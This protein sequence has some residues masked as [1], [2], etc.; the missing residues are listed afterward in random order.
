MAWKERSIVEARVSF[1]TDHAKGLMSMTELCGAYGISRQTGYTWLGRARRGESLRD[2][3]RAPRRCPHRTDAALERAIV[4]MRVRHPTWGPDKI[5]RV[6]SDRQPGKRWPSSTTVGEVLKRH[7]LV[8]PRRRR[9]AID[10]A[11][12]TPPRVQAERANDVWCGDFKGQFRLGDHRYCYPLT[13]SDMHSRYLLGCQA[14]AS[15]RVE[16]SR[17]VFERLFFEHGLPWVMLTDNGVPF[18]TR[19]L[20]G[21]SALSVWWM[22]LGITPVTIQPGKPQQNGRHERMHRTLKAE[23]TRPPGRA[24]DDQQSRFDRF[25][26]EYNHERP[27][28]ALGLDVPASRYAS[29]PRPMPERLPE[30]SYP[31]HFE[32]RRVRPNGCMKWRGQERFLSEVLAGESVGL[33]EVDDDVWS[34]YLGR[35]WLARLRGSTGAV[36]AVAHASGRATP[37]ALRAP[38]AARPDAP[39]CQGCTR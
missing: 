23:T 13:V 30:P 8:T 27:H 5:R 6:L 26:R 17:V 11:K 12:P 1:V 33:E 3:S 16:P 20:G 25:R 31:G 18:A 38:S 32:V 19:G 9:R 35:F 21:L 7:G 28:A 37:V 34:L 24:M 2:R 36:V 39:E 4:D 10:Q 15:T 22:R 29:S 14:L